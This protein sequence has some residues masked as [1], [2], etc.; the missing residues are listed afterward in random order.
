MIYVPTLETTIMKRLKFIPIFILLLITGSA[1]AQEQDT[2][3]LDPLTGTDTLRVGQYLTYSGHI[4]GS[5][6]EQVAVIVSDESMVQLIDSEITYKYDQSEGLSG[7]DAAWKTF[8]FKAE[9]VGQ[10]EIVVQEI[11]RGE[12]IQEST[13]VIVVVE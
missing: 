11:F 1:F 4:H 5:V 3:D 8:L 10:T 2:L 9:K 7:A 6:G 13:V 12:V